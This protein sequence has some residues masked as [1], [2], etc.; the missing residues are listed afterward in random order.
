MSWL[1][2]Y[3][4]WVFLKK[5]WFFFRILPVLALESLHRNRLTFGYLFSG[6]I[7]AREFMGRLVVRLCIWVCAR[8][9][10]ALKLL[11]TSLA[12]CWSSIILLLWLRSSGKKGLAWLLF[13]ISMELSVANRPIWR[14]AS[15]FSVEFYLLKVLNLRLEELFWLRSSSVAFEWV[16]LDSITYSRCLSLNLDTDTRGFSG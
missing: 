14:S 8:S 13:T 11:P 12:R 16:K 5:S 9:G 7:V 3:Y 15:L 1:F 2:I 10:G 6:L 4:E